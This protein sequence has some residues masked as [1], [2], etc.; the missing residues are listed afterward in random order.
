MKAGEID[1]VINAPSGTYKEQGLSEWYL[2]R[3]KAIDL[4]IPLLAN[5]KLANLLVQSLDHVWWKDGIEIMHYDE[6]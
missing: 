3:R 6:F 2:M 4:S 5:I 1:F